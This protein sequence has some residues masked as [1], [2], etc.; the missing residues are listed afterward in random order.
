[1]WQVTRLTL[2]EENFLIAWINTYGLS[3]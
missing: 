1:M 2:K 3:S